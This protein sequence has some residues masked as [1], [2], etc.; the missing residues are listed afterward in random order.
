MTKDEKQALVDRVPFWFHSIDCGDGIVTSGVKPPSALREELRRMALPMLAGKTVADIGAW[1]GFFSFAA[2]ELGAKRVL[3]LDHYVWS[4]NLPRQQQYWKT[5]MQHRLPPVPYHLV[6]GHWEPGTLPGKAGF[7]TIHRIRRSRV[8]QLVADFMTVDL[9]EVGQFDVVFFLGVLYHFEEPFR[10]LRRLSLLTREL[11]V[12]ET[13]AVY[14]PAHEDVGVFE[15][16]ESSELGADIGNWFA[17]NLTGLT[18][19]CR[20]AGFREVRA[21]SPYP[22][23]DPGAASD[24]SLLRYRLTVHALK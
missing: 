6:P 10:A 16:Y 5:C 18:K 20:A 4:M 12:I 21:T 23:T 8:E 7:D 24:G 11:A 19:A 2:E 9:A 14:L 3:A 15:F 1:D 13:A 22:P 17:P